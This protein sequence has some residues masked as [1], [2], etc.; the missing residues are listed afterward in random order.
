[1]VAADSALQRKNMVESQVR[2]SDVTD[3]RITSAMARLPR[4][5]FV[6][7]SEAAVAYSDE[8]VAIGPGRAMAAPR[9][10]AK[11]IQLLDVHESDNVLV[12]GAGRGYSS[13]ILAAMADRVF[14]LET[15]EA[16]AALIGSLAK[17]LEIQKLTP[18]SGPL[19][20][21]WSQ[22][23]PYNGILIDGAVETVPQAILDQL[24]DGGRL[25]AIEYSGPRS[26]AVVIERSGK[27]FSKRSAFDASAPALP[28]FE[29]PAAFSF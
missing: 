12:V 2:T 7:P 3:R 13:A 29:Q 26:S 23:G 17:A 5:R 15:S 6:L 27:V 11:L 22:D 10:T 28:G 16:Q 21:G 20:A 24:K 9:V 1:M 8:A 18:V 25:I 19:S 14:A 4:E